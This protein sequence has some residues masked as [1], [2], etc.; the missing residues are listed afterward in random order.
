MEQSLEGPGPQVG[1]FPCPS[2]NTCGQRRLSRGF[3]KLRTPLPCSKGTT[4]Y[5]SGF[6]NLKNDFFNEAIC[7]ALIS[8]TDKKE[9]YSLMYW[10]P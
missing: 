4:P 3:L 2:G 6:F 7:E 5:N 10:S 8:E 1:T 9:K